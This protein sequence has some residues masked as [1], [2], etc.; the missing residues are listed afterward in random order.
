M[1][2]RIAR[3]AEAADRELGRIQ[4]VYNVTVSLDPHQVAD[5]DHP[6]LLAGT[7]GAVA[8]QLAEFA[9][10]GFNALNLIVAGRDLPGQVEQLGEEVRPAIRR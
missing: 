3:A 7:A 1:V 6:Y 8:E 10:L 4:R 9:S 2:E 5:A